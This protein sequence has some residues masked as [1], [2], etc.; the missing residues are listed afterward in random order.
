MVRL[1]PQINNM[2]NVVNMFRKAI[3]KT[4]TQNEIDLWL[5]EDS[6]NSEWCNGY[7]YGK[8]GMNWQKEA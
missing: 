6:N 2:E 8:P 1:S 4:I 3:D 7:W 5:T